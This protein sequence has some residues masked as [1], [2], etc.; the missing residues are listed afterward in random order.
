MA[1][2]IILTGSRGLRKVAVHGDAIGCIAALTAAMCKVLREMSG[3]PESKLRRLAR[4]VELI[5][6]SLTGR[7]HRCVLEEIKED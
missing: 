7:R 5:A 6:E 2:K 3:T 4:S 1:F